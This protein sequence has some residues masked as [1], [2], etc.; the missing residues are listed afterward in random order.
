MI[1]TA[2]V[3]TKIFYAEHGSFDTHGIQEI[4]HSKLW[5]EVSGAVADFW[6]DLIDHNAH[7]NVIMLIF[8]EFGRRVRDNGSGTDH[9]AAG[10]AFAIGPAVVGG[11]YGE[12]PKTDPYALIEGDL[13]STLDF[14]AIYSE[15]LDSWMG[16]DSRN[17]IENY[18]ET[19]KFIRA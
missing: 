3:G 19:Q 11:M 14:R 5:G 4:T 17:V 7:E 8:S 1:H 12:Y 18:V 6:E 13:I 2:E 9:G 16:L 10:V 15:L